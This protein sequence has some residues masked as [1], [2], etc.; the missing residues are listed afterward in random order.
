M[1]C[2]LHVRLRAV[3]VPYKKIRRSATA[4][5]A[6][7]ASGLVNPGACA[8]VRD[9]TDDAVYGDGGSARFVFES[10]AGVV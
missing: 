9:I 7:C 5:G 8:R 3:A 6:I 2:V 1:W 10:N 4:N